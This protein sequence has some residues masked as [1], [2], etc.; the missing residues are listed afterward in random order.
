MQGQIENQV[1]GIHIQVCVAL[2][3]LSLG[4]FIFEMGMMI[5]IHRLGECL[6]QSISGCCLLLLYLVA[7]IRHRYGC[8]LLILHTCTWTSALQAGVMHPFLPALAPPSE[9]LPI[10]GDASMKQGSFPMTHRTSQTLSFSKS[11]GPSLLPG[12]PLS[13]A[14]VNC[15][16]PFASCQEQPHLL[17]LVGSNS[18][19]VVFSFL[20]L[21]VGKRNADHCFFFS[22]YLYIFEQTFLF[23]L[24]YDGNCGQQRRNYVF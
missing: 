20:G 17:C 2:D 24:C 7:V 6:E 5:P 22:F 15:L 3:K 21:G 4:F 19:H 13:H 23:L 8:L 12:Q 10:P 18:H 16:L 9:V 11:G 14:S 1:T